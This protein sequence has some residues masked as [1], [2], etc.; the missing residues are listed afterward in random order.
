[1]KNEEIIEKIEKWQQC[2]CVHPLTC[3]SDTCSHSN[4]KPIEK[5]GE[6]IM[7]CPAEDCDYKQS[8]IPQCVLNADIDKI[9]DSVKSIFKQIKGNQNG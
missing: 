9:E 6:V 1:M 2:D 4:L 8:Y 5:D 7:I 3:G